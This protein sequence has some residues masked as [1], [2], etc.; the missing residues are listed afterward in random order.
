MSSTVLGLKF[1][2]ATCDQAVDHG[3]VGVYRRFKMVASKM[4]VMVV[5]YLKHNY[6]CQ[7]SEI[8]VVEQNNNEV[9][10]TTLRY[11]Q[12]CRLDAAIS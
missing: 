10:I 11:V 2:T 6:Q 4:I 12:L 5:V 7:V 1:P 8:S 9:S 3:I